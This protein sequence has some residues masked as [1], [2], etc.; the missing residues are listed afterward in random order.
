MAMN[1]DDIIRMAR[2]AGFEVDENHDVWITNGYWLR[3]LERFADLVAAMERE[4]T[5]SAY[6]ERNQLVALLSTC[7]PSGKAKTA[8]EGW[9]EAWHGCVYIEFPWGQASWHYHNSDAWM[10]EHLPPY[11]K[12]WNGHTTEQKYAGIAAAIRARGHYD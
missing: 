7:F 12:Q 4:A 5:S 11:N 8:I 1:R 6:K 10:F 2:E 9:D 3:E